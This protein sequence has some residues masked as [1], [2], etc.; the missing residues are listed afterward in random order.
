MAL[1]SGKFLSFT[2]SLFF[3]VYLIFKHIVWHF[4]I[5]GKAQIRN[6]EFFHSGQEGWID[7]SD[8]R[9]SVAF[10]NLG[11]V[12]HTRRGPLKFIIAKI[13]K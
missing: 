6:V 5:E 12:N 13:L 9:Y 4:V 1:H 3:I 11:Q 8:P 7:D 10:L 2:L